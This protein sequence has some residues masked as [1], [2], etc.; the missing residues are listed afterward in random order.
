MTLHVFP[1]VEQRSE[2][3]FNQRRGI[4][5]ASVVGSLISIGRQTAADFECPECEAVASFPCIGKRGGELKSMHPERAEY[6]RKNGRL[7]IEPASNDT[8]RSLTLHLAA[9]RISGHTEQ[10]YV[11]D[12]MLRG[13]E[14][15]VHAR[16]KYAERY[17]PVTQV[18][19]MVRDYDGFKVGFSPDGLIGEDGAL[20]IKSPRQGNHLKTILADGVPIEHMSQIQC[21]L[22]VSGRKWLDFVSYNG[23]MKL[24]VKRVYPQQAWFDAIISAV[25]AFEA[26]VVEVQRNYDELTVNM[27][28]TERVVEQ[29]MVV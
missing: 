2:E 28:M 1:N 24:W 6:A 16:N 25:R 20:E 12:D 22:M 29:E 4:V 3:W 9:E 8:S 21:G 17:A 26:N 14:G 15:E 27:P 10:T 7:V 18:G 5:T 11:S 19:F 13:I 23:G